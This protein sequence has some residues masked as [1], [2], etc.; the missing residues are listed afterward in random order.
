[1]LRVSSEEVLRDAPGGLRLLFL[2]GG[3]VSLVVDLQGVSEFEGGCLVAAAVAVV[4]GGEDGHA[5]VLVGVAV[6]LHH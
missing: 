3:V 1:V 4:G 6:A 2:G 5:L